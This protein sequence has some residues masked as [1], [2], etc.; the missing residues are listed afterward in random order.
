MVLTDRLFEEVR[1]K[2]N[3]TYAVF[4]Q[5]NN[6]RANRGRLYVTAVNPDTSV[7]V[8]LG[9]VKGLQDTPVSRQLL[10]ET[11]NTFATNYLMGQQTNMG[12]ATSL[13]TWE[14]TG[15]GYQNAAGYIARLHAVT[16]GQLQEAARKYLKDFRWAIVGDP[17]ALKR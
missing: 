8:M 11:V 2:R 10:Q 17:G 5:L 6:R 9:V 1:T 7:K 14:L 4:A 12:Q 16:P 13:A 3:L 15:G